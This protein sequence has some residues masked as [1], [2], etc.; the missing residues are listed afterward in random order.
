[1]LR[2]LSNKMSSAAQGLSITVS[3]SKKPP[4]DPDTELWVGAGL[5][6]EDRQE[7]QKRVRKAESQAISRPRVNLDALK[8][9]TGPHVDLSNLRLTALPPSLSRLT[10]VQNLDLSCNN[11]KAFPLVLESM[12]GHLENLDLSYNQIPNL[13]PAIVSLKKLVSLDASQN[14]ISYIDDS[15]KDLTSLTTLN[16]SGNKLQEVS[17]GVASL[18][19]LKHLLLAKNLLREVPALANLG[20][21]QTLDLSENPL[22]AIDKQRVPNNQLRLPPHLRTLELRSTDLEDMLGNPP[23]LPEHLGRLEKLEL[24]DVSSNPYLSALP[25]GFGTFQLTGKDEVTSSGRSVKLTVKCQ[26]TAVLKG[27][28]TDA[29]LPAGTYKVPEAQIQP[30][31]QGSISWDQP[32]NW[33]HPMARQAMRSQARQLT[34]AQATPPPPPW[35]GGGQPSLQMPPTVNFAAPPN[36]NFGGLGRSAANGPVG[37]HAAPGQGLQPPPGGPPPLQPGVGAGVSTNPANSINSTVVTEIAKAIALVKG[38]PN[39][40]AGGPN[41][42]AADAS[43]N[44]ILRQLADQMIRQIVENGPGLQPSGPYP[45][46]TPAPYYPAPVPAQPGPYPYGYAS[47]PYPL[48]PQMQAGIY[49]NPANL[50]GNPPTWAA[51]A[52]SFQ[53]ARGEAYNGDHRELLQKQTHETHRDYMAHQVCTLLPP[54]LP[55]AAINEKVQE[56]WAEENMPQY[57]QYGTMRSQFEIKQAIRTR[58]IGQLGRSL[59]RQH[60]LNQLA[61]TAMKNQPDRETNAHHLSIAYQTYLAE[62]C[63]L[64]GPVRALFNALKDKQ[65]PPDLFDSIVPDSL[66]IDNVYAMVMSQETAD[67]IGGKYKAWLE[68]QEFWKT[69]TAEDTK[70]V[71]NSMYQAYR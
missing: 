51:G 30:A 55:Q 44:A 47:Q 39:P 56:I 16:L 38:L 42:A 6:N 60:L 15:I 5:S 41:A 53:P 65:W 12:S 66:E 48:Q 36:I 32:V 69:F 3:S 4:P 62:S 7:A 9:R 64:V 70:F 29:R 54:L 31:A 11:L 61:I 10:T 23:A 63:D 22:Q 2:N 34:Q 33:S 37:S 68:Q 18:L 20:T 8:G 24:L 67:L 57:G 49:S 1:M 14:N 27:L 50:Q 45:G 19:Q 25:L 17:S 26:N 58:L 21:L 59:Y 52:G 40:Q 71:A 35:R 28:D 46:V 13:P 43:K